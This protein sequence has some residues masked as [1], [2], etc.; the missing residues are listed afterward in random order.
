MGM[1]SSKVSAVARSFQAMK[2]HIPSIKFPNRERG[3]NSGVEFVPSAVSLS[4]PTTSNSSSKSIGSS[5]RGS[6]IEYDQ[7]PSKYHRKLI[8]PDEMEYIEKGGP[9]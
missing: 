1:A 2:P 9:V 8:T 6:G 5:A 7:L 4:S 3:Q